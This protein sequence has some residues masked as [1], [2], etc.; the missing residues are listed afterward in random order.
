M[1][2]KVNNY[3]W[4]YEEFRKTQDYIEY[5]QILFEAFIETNDK[6]PKHRKRRS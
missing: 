2:Q 3:H 5:N 4:Q 1:E 6:D